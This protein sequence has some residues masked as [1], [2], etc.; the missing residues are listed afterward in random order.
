MKK[1][2]K[3]YVRKKMAL[4]KYMFSAYKP[5]LLFLEHFHS[6]NLNDNGTKFL[7]QKCGKIRV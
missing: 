3:I 2:M 6:R 1:R 4:Q 5:I 7:R